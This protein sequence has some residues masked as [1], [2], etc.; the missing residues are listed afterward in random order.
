[1]K[2]IAMLILGVAFLVSPLLCL[3]AQMKQ[4]AYSG[5]AIGTGGPASAK[6]I[7][8]DFRVNRYT[9]MKNLTNSRRY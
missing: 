2:R 8:F 3:E 4:E 9:M 6:S 5:T 7:G 1:M